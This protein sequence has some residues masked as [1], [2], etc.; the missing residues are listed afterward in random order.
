QDNRGV[1]I[2]CQLGKLKASDKADDNIGHLSADWMQTIYAIS[3]GCL[4]FVFI[5]SSPRLQFAHSITPVSG[6]FLYK[7]LSPAN[8]VTS[9][10]ETITAAVLQTHASRQPACSRWNWA[11]RDEL[12]AFF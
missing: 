6:S 10:L 3:G 5:R 4:R 7:R 8:C 11:P 9:G 2:F 12:W 1:V